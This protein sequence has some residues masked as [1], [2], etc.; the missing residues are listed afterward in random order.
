LH[1]RLQRAEAELCSRLALQRE[2]Q[3]H[4]HG[5]QRAIGR[6]LPETGMTGCRAVSGGAAM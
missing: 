6:G 1:V 3:A 5:D 2:L 4:T